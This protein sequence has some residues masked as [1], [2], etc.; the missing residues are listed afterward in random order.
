MDNFLVNKHFARVELLLKIA[1]VFGPFLLFKFYQ[2]V[3]GKVNFKR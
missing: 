2:G 3:S 1:E